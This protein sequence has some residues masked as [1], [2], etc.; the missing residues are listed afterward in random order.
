MGG[1]KW[2][3]LMEYVRQSRG[4]AHEMGE[5]R[6]GYATVYREHPCRVSHH[7]RPCRRKMYHVYVYSSMWNLAFNFLFCM[8]AAEVGGKKIKRVFLGSVVDDA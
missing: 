8:F 4:R 1:K 7:Q 6:H 3:G 2:G 5:R